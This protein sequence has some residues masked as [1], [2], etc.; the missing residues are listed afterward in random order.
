MWCN[1][2]YKGKHDAPC[3]A[4]PQLCVAR[5]LVSQYCI[6]LVVREPTLKL[7]TMGSVAKRS[8]K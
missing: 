8:E 7:C 2:L 5:H 6:L 1:V 3:E 4:N